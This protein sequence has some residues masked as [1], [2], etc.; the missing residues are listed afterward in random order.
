MELYQFS[1]FNKNYFYNTGNFEYILDDIKYEPQPISRDSFS[2]GLKKNDLTI[3]IPVNLPPFDKT[4]DKTFLVDIKMYIKSMEGDLLFKGVISNTKTKFDEG[5]IEATVSPSEVVGN[6]VIP[7]V[8]YSPKC[9]WALYSSECGVKKA[10]WTIILP[11]DAF[12]V[13]NNTTTF[14]SSALEGKDEDYWAWGTLYSRETGESVMILNSKDD[15]INLLSSFISLQE[16]ELFEVSAGCSKDYP[17][18][19]DKF[20]NNLNYGGFPAIPK[21]NPINQF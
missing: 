7:N 1:V 5:I 21:V 19:R 2:Y 9:I 11:K 3:K 15:T 6:L 17:T 14:K 4:V 16:T 12:T 13:S 10:D 18:C 8:K 20:H